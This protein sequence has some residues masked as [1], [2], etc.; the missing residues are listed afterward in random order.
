MSEG[1][2]PSI[3]LSNWKYGRWKRSEQLP[4]ACN[5]GSQNIPSVLLLDHR[6]LVVGLGMSVR[7]RLERSGPALLGVNKQPT[8]LMSSERGGGE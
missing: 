5:K 7:V 1:R 6:L 3:Y 4:R 2:P 8:Q